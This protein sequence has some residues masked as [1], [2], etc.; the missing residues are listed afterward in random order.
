MAQVLIVDIEGDN[1]GEL[2]LNSKGEPGGVISKIHCICTMDVKTGEER[3]FYGSTLSEGFE[4]LQEAD[5]LIAHNGFSYDYPVMERIFGEALKPRL[6]DTLVMA[7]ILWP[8]R[9]MCPAGGYSLKAIGDFLGGQMKSDYEGGWESFNLDMLKYCQQD[10]RT[11]LDIYKHLI[12]ELFRGNDKDTMSKVVSFEHDFA[13][14]I[15]RQQERGWNFNLD[16]AERLLEEIIIL[17][18]DTEDQLRSIFPPTV[19]YQ[20][21]PQYYLDPETGEKYPTKGSVK[22]KGSGAIKARLEEGPPKEVHTPFNPGSSQQIAERL[23]EKYG[24]RAKK[25]IQI[26]KTTGMPILD[27]E[28]LK[29]AAKDFPEAD[30]ILKYRDVD[31]LRGQLEDWITR[32]THSRIKGAEGPRIHHS[33]NT[34]G[35]VTGRTAASNPNVQQV[36][37]DLR[38]RALWQATPGLVQVGCDLSGIELRCLAHYMAPYDGGDY[39]KQILEGDIHT[40][41]QQAAGLETRTQAKTFI[42]GFLYGAGAAKIGE[43][44]G[45]SV[46][47][48]SALKKK[49]LESLPALGTLI[50]KVTKVAE[51]R[52]SVRLLDGR[53]T[54]VRSAHKALNVLLQ[55]AGAIVS[56]AWCIEVDRQVREAGLRAWQIGFVHDEIQYEAHPDDAEALAQLMEQAAVKCGE[57]LGMA[58]RID[59]EAKIG[60]NW[61][62]VH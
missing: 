35:T 44:V 8:E 22:G 47:A 16:A 3:S 17:K 19:T 39:A 53:V 7:R 55:G 27:S 56:K 59:A 24:K 9:S 57:D 46:K 45:G 49:F 40:H 62:E 36:S 41:N 54:H 51:A 34:L 50:E 25:Y 28:V 21:T 32:A 11:N 58:I 29:A 26:N 37:G 18:R 2:K 30:M 33:L 43:I 60:G 52:S 61:S 20:K 5:A 6:I 38:A 12:K 31:K 15:M 1:L 13:Y 23:L 14:I 10:V 4:Y 42:Y 48:G